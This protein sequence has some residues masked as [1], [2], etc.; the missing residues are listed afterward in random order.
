MPNG[1]KGHFSAAYHE[2]L[3]VRFPRILVSLNLLTHA[4]ESEEKWPLNPSF[5]TNYRA[6]IAIS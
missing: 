3:S 1:S 4:Q 2:F 5:R 6:A